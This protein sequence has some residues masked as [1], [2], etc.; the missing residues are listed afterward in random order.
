MVDVWVAGSI[1]MDLVMRANHFPGPGETVSGEEL[2]V[3]PGGK[4]ANQAVAMAR[5]GKRVGMVGRVGADPFGTALLDNL[6]REGVEACYVT[7][8]KGSSTGAAIIILDAQGDNRILLSP[9][10]NG[11]VSVRDLDPVFPLWESG[12]FLVMQLE[13]PV[14]V[15]LRAAQEARGRGV[16]VILN[17]APAQPEAR[18]LLGDVDFLI[19]NESEAAIL[20]GVAATGMAGAKE[21]ARSMLGL[22]PSQ[23]VVTMGREG[24]WVAAEGIVTH[25]PGVKVQVV[26]TTA[27]GDAFIGAFVTAL[28]DGMTPVE[29]ARFGCCAGAIAVSRLGAQPSLPR[30]WEVVNLC[31][32]CTGH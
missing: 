21:A 9:G 16:R 29:S 27:A 15:V 30:Y 8:A 26:D 28:C 32:S 6:L 22:G 13:I 20:S 24:A 25:I 19:L 3:V 1:N 18:A 10:A 12:Q 4:G 5:L 11:T 31:N 17:A 7:V 14:E 2:L 23:V